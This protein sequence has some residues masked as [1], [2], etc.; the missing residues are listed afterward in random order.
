MEQVN[1]ERRLATILSADVHGYSRMMAEDEVATVRAVKQCRELIDT[2]VREHHGRIVDAPGDNV[3]AEFSSAVEAVQCVVEVQRELADRNGALEPSRRM[4][5]RIGIHV[6][7]VILDDGKIYGDGVNIAARLEASAIP[8]GI[9]I[10]AAVHEQI[11]SKL[12][13]ECED[14]G[15][16]QVKNIPRP[17]RVLRVRMD[18]TPAPVRTSRPSRLRRPMLAAGAAMAAILLALVGRRFLRPKPAAPPQALA[19]RTRSGSPRSSSTRSPTSI[20][21]L[22]VMSAIPATCLRCRMRLPRQLRTRSM[23][24]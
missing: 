23:P 19:N 5:F 11:R 6:G 18:A 12:D 9:C 16:Q 14:I 10:S 8:G 3:L 22:K 13:I 4:A 21:G 1:I 24:N 7:D 17:V 20:C 15:E 2:H